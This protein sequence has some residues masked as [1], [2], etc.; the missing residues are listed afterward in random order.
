M[1]LMMGASAKKN[2]LSLF[3][4]SQRRLREVIPFD[5]ASHVADVA[6][7]KIVQ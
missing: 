1:K 5:S 3:D 2:L 4:K 6:F 7:G